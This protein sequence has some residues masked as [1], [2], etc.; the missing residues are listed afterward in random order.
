MKG[1]N[2][3]HFSSPLLASFQLQQAVKHQ[4]NSEL[5]LEIWE[6]TKVPDQ[7]DRKVIW[8]PERQTTARRDATL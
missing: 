5:E 6:Q 1:P 7:N 2:A 3:G 8:H 4:M